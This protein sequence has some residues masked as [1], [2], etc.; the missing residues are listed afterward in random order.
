MDLFPAN[1]RRLASDRTGMA[2]GGW[3]WCAGPLIQ[4]AT[5][6]FAGSISGI[7]SC[8]SGLVI[9]LSAS[10]LK[11]VFHCL[12]RLPAAAGHLLRSGIAA[13]GGCARGILTLQLWRGAEL[14]AVPR[15]SIHVRAATCWWARSDSFRSDRATAGIDYIHSNRKM[16]VTI[17]WVPRPSQPACH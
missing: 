10:G 14:P 2:T 3:C 16:P 17:S 8:V 6:P 13:R 11:T 1:R 12:W 7:R 5:A 9:M 15:C 4:R